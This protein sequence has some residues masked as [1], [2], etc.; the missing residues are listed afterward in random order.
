MGVWIETQSSAQHI[1]EHNVTPFVGVW[2][3][4]KHDPKQQIAQPV[5]P[6]VGVWIETIGN[7]CSRITIERHTLRGCVD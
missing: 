3:E 6:F 7:L 5:T 4:T 2:I 1:E